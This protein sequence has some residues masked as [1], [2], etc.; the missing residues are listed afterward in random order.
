MDG[1]N[2]YKTKPANA[3]LWVF[4]ALCGVLG[5]L[6]LA[7]TIADITYSEGARVGVINKF[8]RKGIVFKTHEG[9]MALEGVS[10]TGTTVGMNV[11]QF[12]LDNSDD[13]NNTEALATKILNHMNK[14]EK[15]KVTYRQ[16]LHPWPWRAKTDYL[17]VNVEPVGQ[18]KFGK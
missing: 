15:V 12:S 5:V 17:V 18:Q 3:K 14:S 10:S 8:S 13:K 2:V 7:G 16:I 6:M 1:M 4:L 9:E 11:W